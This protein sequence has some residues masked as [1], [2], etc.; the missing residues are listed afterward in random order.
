MKKYFVEFYG[1]APISA[2][3]DHHTKSVVADTIEEAESYVRH[4]N[5]YG[6]WE[7]D[8][9]VVLEDRTGDEEITF[10]V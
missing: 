9:E 6:R 2:T 7:I 1:S 5:R 8:G 10:E 3:P 4:N